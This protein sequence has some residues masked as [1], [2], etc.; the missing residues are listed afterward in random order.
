MVTGQSSPALMEPPTVASIS[1]RNILGTSRQHNVDG[2]STNTV[3]LSLSLPLIPGY[4][5]T[6]PDNYNN[7]KNICI[8]PTLVL[9]PT[10][11]V[12]GT[13][14]NGLFPDAINNFRNHSDC[15]DDAYFPWQN[16]SRSS[17]HRPKLSSE[18]LPL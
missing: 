3:I 12:S 10:S 8:D 9:L 1:L 17:D 13:V 2:N 18:P 15:I 16:V 5:G 11:I 6:K 7:E 4:Y 14:N